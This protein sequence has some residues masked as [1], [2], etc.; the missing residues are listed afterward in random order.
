MHDKSNIFKINKWSRFL[1]TTSSTTIKWRLLA[2]IWYSYSTYKST[3]TIDLYVEYE[4]QIRA[5]SLHPE[6][7]DNEQ[8][9]NVDA[10]ANHHGGG[11][12]GD[13]TT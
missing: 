13:P 3:D 7:L 9:T 5:R 8:D 10:A 1:G 6:G 12:G 11:G 2:R 4:Y